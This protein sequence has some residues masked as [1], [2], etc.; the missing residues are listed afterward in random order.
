MQREILGKTIG[1][2]I[3][4]TC[5]AP[6]SAG[7]IK[8]IVKVGELDPVTKEIKALR[9]E[10]SGLNNEIVTFAS[11]TK[12]GVSILWVEGRKRY[13]SA[14]AIRHGLG[15]DRRFRVFYSELLPDGKP[16][17]EQTDWF[18]FD[19]RHYDVIVIGDVTASRFAAVSPN[20]FK[21]IN[22]LVHK[23]RGLLLIG[24]HDAFANG[25]W[26]TPIAQDL[27]ALLPVRLDMPGH[28]EQK[29]QMQPTTDGLAY[30]LRLDADAEKNEKIWDQDIKVEG[31]PRED[32]VST[33]WTACR[34]S[35]PRPP[36]PRSSP[37][38]RKA[39]SPS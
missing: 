5:D 24:G 27:A 15:G 36:T 18:D 23:G 1:N 35:G 34:G 28:I 2:E 11:V 37:R 19:K 6:E 20:V 22:D 38:A 39:K 25:D 12:E 31:S 33:S 10:V 30:L 4:L 7:E 26:N 16:P 17:S 29:V 32:L 3:V 9:G 13:E 8:I 14:F 21:K